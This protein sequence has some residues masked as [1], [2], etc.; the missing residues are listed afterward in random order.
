MASPL[1]L[2]QVVVN[3]QHRKKGSREIEGERGKGSDRE[4]KRVGEEERKRTRER[5]K[6]R[7]E[8]ER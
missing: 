5:G 4:F 3:T 1:T 7:Q 6:S 2:N 8:K